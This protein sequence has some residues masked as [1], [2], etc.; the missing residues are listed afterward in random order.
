MCGIQNY[1]VVNLTMTEDEYEDR[2]H[3]SAREQAE[4]DKEENGGRCEEC[5][6]LLVEERKY[7][8]VWG[9]EFCDV[10]WVCPRCD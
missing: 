8:E 3:E 1:I 5:G 6:M 4:N 2:Y 7:E 9:N 10:V